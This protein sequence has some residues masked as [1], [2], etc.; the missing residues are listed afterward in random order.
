[1]VVRPQCRWYDRKI[2]ELY[3]L[4]VVRLFFTRFLHLSESF[5]LEIYLFFCK[6]EVELFYIYS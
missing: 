1:M 6:L 5:E 3:F 4:P 2:I